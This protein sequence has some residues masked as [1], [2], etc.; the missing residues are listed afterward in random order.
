MRSKD[1]GTRAESAVVK[2]CHDLGYREAERLALAGSQDRGDIRLMRDPLVILEVKAGKAAQNA[3]WPQ[4]QAWLKETQVERNRAWT[5]A[6]E[7]NPT[8]R[9][10]MDFH[11]FLVT[12]RK[13]YGI[14]RVADWCIWT[15]D[16]DR[17][18]F[19]E[20]EPW[21]PTGMFP[22]GSFLDAMREV[23]R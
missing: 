7:A 5:A 10:N 15:L 16:D 17:L 14:G 3:S 6:G 19:D 11:G 1:I 18:F 9:L 20:D 4:I 12:Q 21:I 23:W 2:L 22:L 13:G 8:G